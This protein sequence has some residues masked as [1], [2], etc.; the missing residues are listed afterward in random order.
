MMRRRGTGRK[1]RLRQLGAGEQD[2]AALC[3]QSERRG[4]QANGELGAKD[5]VNAAAISISTTRCPLAMPPPSV[6]ICRNTATSRS[7]PPVEHWSTTLATALAAVA[8]FVTCTHTDTRRVTHARELFD[9]DAYA[10]LA[11][12]APRRA[13]QEGS[14]CA[15]AG[16]Q[17]A[18]Q[19]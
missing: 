13:A 18:V 16:P 3:Q 11:A 5:D 12:G 15:P 8:V 4:G 14:P 2:A 9:A 10:V 1:R 17:N 7:S 19:P 6:S